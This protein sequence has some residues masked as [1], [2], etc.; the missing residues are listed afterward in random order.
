LVSLELSASRGQLA[1]GEKGQLTV[2]VRGTEQ[3]LEL[4]ARNLTPET[5][6]LLGGETQR[7]ITRGG[8]ENASVLQL[9]GRKAGEFSISV[10]LIPMASGLP[11]TEAARQKLLAARRV[12]PSGWGWRIDRVIEKI[13]KNPQ[14]ALAARN[15]LEKLLALRPGGEF[16]ALIEDAWQILLILR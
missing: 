8:A 5:I 16:G 12:A 3:R 14:N 2:R 10:R 6:R 9:Q 13:E 11:D 1:P 7:V 15:E 4:E